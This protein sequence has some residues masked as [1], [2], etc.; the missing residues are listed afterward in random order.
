MPDDGK[1]LHFGLHRGGGDLATTTDGQRG[2]L[3]RESD[4]G[5]GEGTV[6]RAN[7]GRSLPIDLLKGLAILAVLFQHTMSAATFYRIGA[8]IYILQAVGV[9]MILAGYNGARSFARHRVTTLAQAYAW[10][11]LGRSLLR[12]VP[13]YLLVWLL[14]VVLYPNRGELQPGDYVSSLLRGGWGWGNYFVPVIVTNVLL[15]PL[16]YRLALGWPAL[17]LPV[18]F[19]LDLAFELFA[20]QAQ[21][22][23]GFY[24]GNYLRYL[25]AV[26]LGIWLA[27]SRP[28]PGWL[29]AFWALSLV[30]VYATEYG[31]LAPPLVHV[32]ASRSALGA[33]VA[34][35]CVVLGLLYLPRHISG[36]PWRL[37]G[38][39]GQASYHIFLLQGSYFWLWFQPRSGPGEF[40]ASAVIL[41]VLGGLGWLFYRAEQ[42]VRQAWQG[43]L[44]SRP[45]SPLQPGSAVGPARRRL[46]LPRRTDRSRARTRSGRESPG[47]FP[48]GRSPGDEADSG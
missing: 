6:T 44:S 4:S 47:A 33:G 29:S 46:L 34:L 11:S 25:F 27:R 38:Q 20:L 18:A 15:F 7:A 14:E 8:P 26:A 31:W 40:L 9:F 48:P 41:A 10:P 2:E 16:L 13:L 19:G 1:P 22:P 24:E 23:A 21:L 17:L 37:L 12:L 42:G 30:F 43:R 32:W 39:L 35:G 45:T 28:R 5:A 36:L 3:P